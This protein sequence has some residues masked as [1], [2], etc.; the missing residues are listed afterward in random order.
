MKYLNL[1]RKK[2][3][4]ILKRKKYSM[5]YQKY[6]YINIHIYTERERDI[7]HFLNNDIINNH[8]DLENI[9]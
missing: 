1:K 5:K 4:G 7:F 9:Y 3:I 6:V 8:L 2:Q